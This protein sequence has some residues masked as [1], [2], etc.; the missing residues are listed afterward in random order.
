MAYS[1]EL[2]TVL[3]NIFEAIEQYKIDEEHF[4]SRMCQSSNPSEE[5]LPH[6]EQQLDFSFNANKQVVVENFDKL[7]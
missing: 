6:E 1:K 7:S 2:R 3:I 5:I 4:Y